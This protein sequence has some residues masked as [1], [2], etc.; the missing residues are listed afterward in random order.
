[1]SYKIDGVPDPEDHH[2]RCTNRLHL[3]MPVRQLY[4]S[5]YWGIKMYIGTFLRQNRVPWL[6]FKFFGLFSAEASFFWPKAKKKMSRSR[7]IGQRTWKISQGTQDFGS[8]NVPRNPGSFPFGL[9]RAKS[10]IS[11][12]F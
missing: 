1:M 5:V 10:F 6:F 3:H 7:K 2:Q 12:I 9:P 4:Q 8:K 11:L